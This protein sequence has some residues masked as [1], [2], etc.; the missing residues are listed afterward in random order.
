MKTD[1]IVSAVQQSAGIDT[2]EHARRAVHATINVLGH[3][4]FGG[5]TKDL[6]SQLPDEF[7]A[8]LPERG[9]GER[10]GVGE[11]YQRV[12]DTEGL[13][14]T[15]QQARQHARAVAAAL[16]VAVTGW[17]FDH[18]AAQLPR[19]YEDLLSTGPVQHH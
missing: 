7:A 16:K 17:E 2:P 6:A 13:G 5:E 12:S 15:P 3:R 18:M 14:C 4:L 10:F 11:F 19:E 1:E 9:P 8:E